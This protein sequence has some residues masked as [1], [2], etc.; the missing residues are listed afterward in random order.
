[1][2]AS[3][4]K[5]PFSERAKVFHAAI[6]KECLPCIHKATVPIIMIRDDQIVHNRT[7]V[8]YCVGGCH[9]VLTAAHYL[10][11]HVKENTFL[12]LS[13]TG[14]IDALLPLGDAL[15]HSTEV[16]GRGSR[17]VAAIWIPEQTAIE[18]RKT[19]EFVRHNQ[20]SMNEDPGGLYVFFGYPGAWAGR[21]VSE[22][23]AESIPLVFSTFEVR[24]PDTRI[25]AYDRNVHLLL[26]YTTS[27]I[28]V[29]T[30]N[31]DALPDLHGISGCGIWRVGDKK[32]TSAI[33]RNPNTLTLVAIQHTWCRGPSCVMA[34]RIAFPLQMIA[35]H[36]EEASRAMDLVYPRGHA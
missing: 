18:L 25:D 35:S 14:H 9:F 19:K 6:E 36:Y 24:C 31:V 7:G 30:G 3:E 15:F 5:Q 16:Y 2:D 10:R 8:L 33:P 26:N 22:V 21:A 29:P 4:G 12:G 13:P 27:A 32:G 1:M 17:D 28:H 34:T 20:I 11:D 23:E